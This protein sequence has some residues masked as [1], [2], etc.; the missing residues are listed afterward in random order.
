[1]SA[2]SS[3]LLKQRNGPNQAGDGTDPVA[4]PGPEIAV[5]AGAASGNC[6]YPPKYSNTY[7]NSRKLSD[8]FKNIAASRG[9]KIDFF[10]SSD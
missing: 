2:E 6:R 7:G 9:L 5:P 3:P 8:K 10:A 4:A 1:M